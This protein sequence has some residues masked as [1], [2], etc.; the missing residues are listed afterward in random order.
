VAD[1]LL[2][3]IRQA[4]RTVAGLT[5]SGSGRAHLDL[6][7]PEDGAPAMFIL[8]AEGD[9]PLEVSWDAPRPLSGRLGGM[10]L[11]PR[12]G[13]V[14]CQLAGNFADLFVPAG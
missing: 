9:G 6:L 8:I 5:V 13:R 3:R 4:V 10:E 7:A 11:S 12:S 1:M 2:G 14:T